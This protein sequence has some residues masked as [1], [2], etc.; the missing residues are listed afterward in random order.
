MKKTTPDEEIDKILDLARTEKPISIENIRTAAENCGLY[1]RAF[2]DLLIRKAREREQRPTV[3]RIFAT[4]AT[5]RVEHYQADLERALK[6]IHLE[7][8]EKPTPP[9]ERPAPRPN[10]PM[11]P[12]PRQPLFKRPARQET[13]P[14]TPEKGKR[15]LSQEVIRQQ[16]ASRAITRKGKTKAELQAV[17]DAISKGHDAYWKGLSPEERKAR[18]KGIRAKVMQREEQRILKNLGNLEAQIREFKLPFKK[19]ADKKRRYRAKKQR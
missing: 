17:R 9:S 13:R 11:I 8:H 7:K 4:L 6:S 18:V 5:Q 19:R 14:N 15:T 16:N 1:P 12:P 2:N 3:N 10:Q